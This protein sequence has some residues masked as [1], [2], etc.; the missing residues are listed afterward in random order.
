MKPVEIEDAT[1]KLMDIIES[2]E[3]E[4]ETPV[5]ITAGEAKRIELIR[6]MKQDTDKSEYMI[7]LNI[8]MV[9]LTIASGVHYFYF[10]SIISIVAFV[11]GL[12][13]FIFFRKRI[14]SASS[15]LAEYKNDFDRYLWEGFYLKE[16]RYNGVRLAY[17]LFFPLFTVFLVDVLS[18]NAEYISF[19]ISIII[20]AVISTIGWMIFF[21]NDQHTL[22]IIE[23]D[24]KSLHYL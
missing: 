18:E 6:R 1:K 19:Y 5:N 8:L 7:M 14:K 13:Y 17:L 10:G 11:I 16:M 24:L 22:D 2:T 23:S 9:G 15:M 3:K 21:K 20:A 12:G 4:F